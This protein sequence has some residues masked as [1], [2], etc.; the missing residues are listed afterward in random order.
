MKKLKSLCVMPIA[1]ETMLGMGT[2]LNTVSA[3]EPSIPIKAHAYELDDKSSYDFSSASEVSSMTFGKKTLGEF[4]ISANVIETGTYRNTPAYGVSG[5]VSFSYSYDG[6]FQTSVL[7]N[8]N[9]ITDEGTTVGDIELS[10]SI[11]KGALIVQTCHDGSTWNNAVNPVTNFYESNPSGR[12]DFYTTSGEDIAQGTYYRVIFAYKMGQKTGTT[13][14]GP[15]KKDVFA[16]KKHVEVY[17]FY[18]VVGEG[19]ISIHNLATDS[20]SF[21]NE[22][23]S[24]TVLQKGETLVDGSMTTKGFSIDKLGSSVLVGVSKDGGKVSYVNDGATFTENGRY[25]VT[26]ITKFGKQRSQTIYVFNGSSDNGFS[27]VSVNN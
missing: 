5:N 16:Y 15:W 26:T 11:G 24:S 1:L 23:V 21:E 9:L 14:W 10:G 7:E 8:W 17:Q 12:D 13:G 27:T 18:L 3:Q 20:T 22:G 19:N 25:T 6:S 4:S 2:F